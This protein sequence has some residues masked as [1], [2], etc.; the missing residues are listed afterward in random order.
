MAYYVRFELAFIFQ[1]QQTASPDKIGEEYS[2]FLKS[3]VEIF[4]NIS[5]EESFSAQYK[6]H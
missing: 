1:E 4:P 5:N 3:A 2:P 6:N